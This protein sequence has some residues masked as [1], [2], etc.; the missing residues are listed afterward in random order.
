M[1]ELAAAQGEGGGAGVGEGGKR[2]RPLRIKKEIKL[3]LFAMPLANKSLC[4]F[5]N[6]VT[7]SRRKVRNY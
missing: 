5:I 2:Q 6:R 3:K 1:R 4:L 7:K